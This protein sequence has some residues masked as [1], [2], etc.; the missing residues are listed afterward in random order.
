MENV[1]KEVK[2][3][4]NNDIYYYFA[5]DYDKLFC[6]AAEFGLNWVDYCIS[7]L[8]IGTYVF[9]CDWSKEFIIMSPELFTSDFTLKYGLREC[10]HKA[11]VEGIEVM[12]KIAAFVVAK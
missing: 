2:N 8:P 12:K 3:Q 4:K 11:T 10:N 9:A 1:V 6:N 5:I 7:F